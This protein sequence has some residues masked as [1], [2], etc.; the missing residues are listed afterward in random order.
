ME[1]SKQFCKDAGVI[2]HNENHSDHEPVYAVID[3]P[4]IEPELQPEQAKC[5]PKFDW[6]NASDDQK[7]EFNDILFRK[8]MMLQIP[9][10]V[11]GCRNLKCTEQS[12]TLEIDQYVKD[13]LFEIVEAGDSSIPKS[14]PKSENQKNKNTP[15]WNTF[16]KPFQENAYFWHAIWLS[17]GRPMNVEVHKIIHK[18]KDD[19]KHLLSSKM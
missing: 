6:K 17:C 7:L 10:C 3:C 14:K 1:R 18:I 9:D 11:E 16:V 19:K 4:R 2:H 5:T 8:L 15:G 12:H 13:L